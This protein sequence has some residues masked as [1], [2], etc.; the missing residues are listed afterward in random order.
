MFSKDQLLELL[1][2]LSISYQ[3]YEHEP[4]FTVE[5]AH[6]A[7]AALN[8]PGTGIKNLF[9]KDS[10]KKLYLVVACADAVIKLKELGKNIGA[11]ELRF[12][13]AA[14][15]KEYLGV[16]PGSV[17]PLALVNDVNKKV[18]VIL[19]ANIFNQPFIQLHPLINTAT[20]IITP[21]ALKKFLAHYV[22]SLSIYEF[23][24]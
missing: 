15:L 16:E 11:P 5:Q 23:V 17:T 14:L 7:V 21:D 22:H 13:D 20:V 12:A 1:T 19:D 10:K 4:L 8:M 6:K 9:L 3:L 24:S 18:T 2:D